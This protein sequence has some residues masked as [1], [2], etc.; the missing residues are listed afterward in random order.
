MALQVTSYLPRKVAYSVNMLLKMKP[1]LRSDKRKGTVGSCLIPPPRS[2]E[3]PCF[4]CRTYHHKCL[5]ISTLAKQYFDSI[6]NTF[7]FSWAFSR[8]GVLGGSVALFVVAFVAYETARVLLMA[9]RSIFQRT[10]LI[11]SY[12]EIASTI[13]EDDRWASFVRTA[14]IVSCIGGCCGYM[15]FLGQVRVLFLINISRNLLF[16]PKSMLRI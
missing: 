14:T 4:R 10:G 16:M 5:S 8:A 11:L 12:P 7:Y 9:Q 1:Q 15:I 13:F 6:S 3:P 2:L